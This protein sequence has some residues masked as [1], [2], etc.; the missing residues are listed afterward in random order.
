LWS[1]SNPFFVL[2]GFT[3]VELLVVIA[4]I[5]MLIALLLPAVQAARAA[6]SRMECS[7]KIRQIALASHNHHDSYDV[8]PYGVLGQIQQ[9]QPSSKFSGGLSWNSDWRGG[10]S[11]FVH[12]FPF[13]ELESV[14][15]TT[16]KALKHN[17]EHFSLHEPC[18]IDQV[19]WWDNVT[20]NPAAVTATLPFNPAEIE[21]PQFVCPSCSAGARALGYD[22]YQNSAKSNYNGMI[23]A[24]TQLTWTSLGYDYPFNGVFVPNKRFSFNDIT[25]G[26]SNTLFFS[27]CSA[28]DNPANSSQWFST[29]PPLIG[30]RQFQYLGPLLNSAC[31]NVKCKINYANVNDNDYRASSLHLGGANFGIGD[32]SVRFISDTINMLLYSQLATRASD[33]PV[34]VP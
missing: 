1:S 7:N 21:L 23:G 12:L 17:N 19:T 13:M 8:L 15:D 5:G 18:Q 30:Y 6:A 2:L 24:E 31:N 29:A 22:K 10:I 14:Q 16:L 27:E 26:T 4:I 25:D 34:T 28:I 32:G 11:L 20:T 33:E 3:L 9:T